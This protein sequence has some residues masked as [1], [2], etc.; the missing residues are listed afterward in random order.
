MPDTPDLKAVARARRLAQTSRTTGGRG[1]Q[2]CYV[3]WL[4]ILRGHRG[5]RTRLSDLQARRHN[6]H[7]RERNPENETWPLIVPGGRCSV[8]LVPTRLWTILGRM[9]AQRGRVH[10]ERGRAMQVEGRR[11]SDIG[12]LQQVENVTQDPGQ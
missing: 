7:R 2:D 11:M 5:A 8:A 6:V 10:Q 1:C 9:P 12:G 4:E 3:T